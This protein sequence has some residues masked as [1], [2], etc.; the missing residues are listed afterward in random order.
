MCVCVRVRTSGGLCECMYGCVHVCV[1][2]YM[3]VCVDCVSAWVHVCV[4]CVHVCGGIV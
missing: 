2:V 1:A 3:C 4:C